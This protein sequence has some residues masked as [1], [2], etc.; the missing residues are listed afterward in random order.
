MTTPN[1]RVTVWIVSK[2]WREEKLIARAFEGT[3]TAKQIRLD[4]YPQ[5]SN[6]TIP[7]SAYAQVAFTELDAVRNYLA[8]AERKL[9]YAREMLASR[10]ED[11]AEARQLLAETEAKP[12]VGTR[13]AAEIA[14]QLRD[15][16]RKLRG[17]TN[18]E[19]NDH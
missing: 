5:G 1:E 10:E 15:H 2:P 14:G 13:L 17:P 7:E 3:K 8:D 19:S 12:S 4:K 16:D 9:K 18:K 11:V 6:R